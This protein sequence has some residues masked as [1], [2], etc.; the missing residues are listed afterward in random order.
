MEDIRAQGAQGP[1]EEQRVKR[2]E[3][4]KLEEI[5]KRYTQKY[6]MWII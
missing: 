4:R 6:Y 1:Q 2:T 3:N 5:M